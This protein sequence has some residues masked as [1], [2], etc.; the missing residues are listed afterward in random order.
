MQIRLRPQQEQLKRGGEFS[1]ERKQ[2]ETRI[3]NPAKLSFKE[4]KCTKK[5]QSLEELI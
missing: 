1:S 2:C 3:V 4:K 5:R